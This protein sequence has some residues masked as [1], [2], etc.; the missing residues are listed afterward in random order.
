VSKNSTYSKNDF[1]NL[2][3]SEFEHL[4]SDSEY[5]DEYLTSL[6]LN[7]DTIADEGIQQLKRKILA[8]KIEKTKAEM[9][10]AESLKQTVLG[11]V[12]KLLLDKTFKFMDFIKTER[13]QLSFRNFESFTPIEIK[14]ILI[15]HYTLKL[16]Q[17]QDKGSTDG[18]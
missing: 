17:E 6:G 4:S 15:Q 13:P 9:A 7:P 18:L 11:Q 8:I 16:L 10:R 1:L 2:L 5:A 12:E 3:Y 14:D